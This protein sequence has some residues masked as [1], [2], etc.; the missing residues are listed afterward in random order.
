MTIR[1]LVALFATVISMDSKTIEELEVELGEQLKELRLRKNID[2]KALAIRAGC[3]VSAIKALESGSGTRLK[4][5][6]AVV[7]ALGREEWLAS[8][9]PTASIN[10]LSLTSTRQT[11]QRAR[12]SKPNK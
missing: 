12:S 7:R 4:T 5:L 10:P 11:R 3:S 9:A 2:Q 8:I 1:S 6:L